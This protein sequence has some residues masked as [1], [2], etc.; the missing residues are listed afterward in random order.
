MTAPGWSS[1]AEQNGNVTKMRFGGFGG[2]RRIRGVLKKSKP[3][4]FQPL[5]GG[6]GASATATTGRTP[7]RI[8]PGG[9]TAPG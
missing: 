9:M 3:K 8:H 4:A 2:V 1:V 5:A 7:P 6:Q